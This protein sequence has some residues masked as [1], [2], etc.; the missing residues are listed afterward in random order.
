[1]HTSTP[2]FARFVARLEQAEA[3]ARGEHGQLP[4]GHTTA[5]DAQKLHVKAVQLFLEEVGLGRFTGLQF[6]LLE[7]F[8]DLDRGNPNNPLLTPAET[9]NRP[10]PL[11]AAS[12][13]QARAARV[14]DLLLSAPHATRPSAKAAAR[15]IWK[16]RPDWSGVFNVP[17]EI[18]VLRRNIRAGHATPD[19]LRL[20]QMPLPAA[21]FG[22]SREDQVRSLLALLAENS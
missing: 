6:A 13:M 22:A 19:I 3:V 18:I 9:A 20:W 11:L 10:P 16:A 7:A 15:A 17:D 8:G 21:E 5:R 14:L 4:P 12:R 1:M 2:A